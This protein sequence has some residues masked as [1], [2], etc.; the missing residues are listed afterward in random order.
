MSLSSI[1]GAGAHASEDVDLA[2]HRLQ[3]GRVDAVTDS[4]QVV[5]LQTFGN[6]PDELLI[7]QPM[8][9][10]GPEQA[11]PIAMS[12]ASPEPARLRLLNARPEPAMRRMETL[13]SFRV[14]MLSPTLVVGRAPA[15]SP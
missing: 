7:R 1:D 13:A 2:S 11:V 12:R 15:A 5:E 9:E 6:R 10:L 8:D 14:A 4:T 3:M